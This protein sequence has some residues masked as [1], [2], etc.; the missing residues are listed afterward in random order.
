MTDPNQYNSQNP[1][2]APQYGG[3]GSYGQNDYGQ[4]A[5]QYDAPDYGQQAP[6]YGSPQYSAPQYN[7]AAGYNQQQPQYGAPQPQG[8]NGFFALTAPLDQPAYNCT[9]GEAFIRF[10]KKYA[11]FKGRASRGEFWWWILCNCI[12]IAVLD[13]IIDGDAANGIQ[14]TVN[15]IWGLATIIPSLALSVRRLHD[16]NKPGTT[17]VILYVANLIGATVIGVFLMGI[18]F[19]PAMD[20]VGKS[21][22]AGLL[23]FLLASSP[24]W[25]RRSYSSCSWPERPIRPAYASTTLQ[26]ATVIPQFRR[27]RPQPLQPQT[28]RTAPRMVPTD[29]TILPWKAVSVTD[30]RRVQP[31]HNHVTTKYHLQQSVIKIPALQS[32]VPGFLYCHVNTIIRC[33][34]RISYSKFIFRIPVLQYFDYCESRSEV[35]PSVSS[36]SAASEASLESDESSFFDLNFSASASLLL[37]SSSSLA[38][39]SAFFGSQRRQSA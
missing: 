35:P 29:P 3:Y 11:T 27:Y 5:P 30:E 1:Q 17:L 39:R 8:T 7:N 32:Q 28:L 38:S 2:Q 26:P 23:L 37:R 31:N 13:A 14:R 25:P 21:D 18:R 12:I 34:D 19:T 22:L 33:H 15:A 24:S 4:Q 20:G 9:I 6:Q 10:W 16:I 36:A